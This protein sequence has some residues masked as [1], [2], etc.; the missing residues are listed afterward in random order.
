VGGK[1]FT[2]E[3]SLGNYKDVGGGLM[4]PHSADSKVRAAPMYD[5]VAVIEKV[6]INIDIDDSVFKMPETGGAK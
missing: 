3:T 4:Y 6:E 2:A 5:M 1:E